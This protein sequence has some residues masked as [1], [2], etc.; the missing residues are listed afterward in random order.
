MMRRIALPVLLLC[1]LFVASGAGALPEVWVGTY[2]EP[3]QRFDLGGN[4]LGTLDVNGPAD[5]TLDSAHAIELI[6]SEVWVGSRS[7]GTTGNNIHRFDLSGNYVGGIDTGSAHTDGI[8]LIPEPN[9][10]RLRGFGLVG[11]G[12]KRRRQAVFH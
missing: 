4:L 5:P 10:G 8:A 3:L 7:S 6:G 11:L 12:I 9:T 1:G 2:N